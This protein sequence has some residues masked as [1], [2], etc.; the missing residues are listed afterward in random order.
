MPK[1]SREIARGLRLP[2]A[3]HRRGEADGIAA[4]LPGRGAAARVGP[5]EGAAGRPGQKAPKT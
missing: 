1:A 5:R 2:D 4:G 3:G